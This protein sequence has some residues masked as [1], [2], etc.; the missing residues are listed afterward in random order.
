[1]AIHVQ[2]EPIFYHK[3][4]KIVTSDREIQILAK[5]EEPFVAVLGNVLSEEECEELIQ[6]SKDH[7][8]RSKIGSQ[9]DVNSI[10]TSSG[11]FLP[12]MADGAVARVEKR[13]AEIMGIPLEHGE[14]LHILNYQPGQ[15][16]K[17]HYDYFTSAKAN[18]NPRISTLVM[19]LNDVEEGG[20]TYF[21]HLK[22]SVAPQRGMA[23][24]FEYFY[25][26]QTLNEMTLHG[27]S[28]VVKGEKWAATQWVRRKQYR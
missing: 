18:S 16:Y 13:V 15:E 17:A 19:Y 1:M 27:G 10:R 24:Y 6:V 7:L 9:R 5:I 14:G 21:P 26:D 22:L 11:A 25:K 4:S 2:E 20:E 8:N 12:E 3:G 23:V 28:P